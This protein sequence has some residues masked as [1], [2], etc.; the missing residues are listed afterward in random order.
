MIVVRLMGGLDNQMFQYAAGLRLALR[1]RTEL[2]LDLSFL[3][4]R[5]PRA[6][7][8]PREFELDVFG[9]PVARADEADIDPFRRLTEARRR[10]FGDALLDRF[11]P[12]ACFVENGPWF[13]ARVLQLPRRSYLHGY[14]QNERY[15]ADIAPLIRARFD[16]DPDESTLPRETVELAARMRAPESICLHVRR[17]D[18]VSNPTIRGVHGVCSRTYYERALAELRTRGAHGR[19]YV[20][21]DDPEGCGTAFA[22]FADATIVGREHAGPRGSIHLWLMTLCQHFIVANSS[23]SWWAA[24]LGSR[25]G[26]RVVRPSPWFQ[27]PALRSADLCP[28][29]WIAV[30][31]DLS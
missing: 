7:V 14:F 11:A 19:V 23:F 13:D 24:W 31:A 8:T 1:H 22:D 6:D 20:F 28:P 30:P 26:K 15:F 17:G 10:S 27:L 25:A 12:R 9:F 21:S 3:E 18:Y 29:D 2:K 16:V 4:D 5:T